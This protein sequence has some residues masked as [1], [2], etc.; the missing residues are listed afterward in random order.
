[1]TS[2]EDLSRPTREHLLA[3]GVV[4][5][6]RYVIDIGA[7]PGKIVRGVQRIAAIA[8]R[9]QTALGLLEFDHALADAGHLGHD[10]NLKLQAAN[11]PPS[12]S[13]I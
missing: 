9:I 13:S 12:S 4:T 10:R 1:V 3:H 11:L 8:P 5:E 2:T 6:R 7:E